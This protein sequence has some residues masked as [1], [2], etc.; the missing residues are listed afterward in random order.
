M[1]S[2]ALDSQ[3][4]GFSGSID[5]LSNMIL[6]KEVLHNN[7]LTGTVPSFLAALPRLNQLSLENNMLT[8]PLPKFGK[9][10]NLTFQPINRL[11]PQSEGLYDQ[12][13]LLDIAQAFGQ[14]SNASTCIPNSLEDSRC[15]SN[16]DM[17]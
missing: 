10:V 7:F 11:C 14:F 5:V 8:G 4:S 6:L 9:H 16:G 2:L 1:E 15:I 13:V 12:M 17:Y 3:K